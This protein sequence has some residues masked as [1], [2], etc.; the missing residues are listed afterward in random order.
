[1]LLEIKIESKFSCQSKDI[2]NQK[3][4]HFLFFR[5]VILWFLLNLRRKLREIKDK[6][7]K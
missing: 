5:I 7:V 3:I 2:T 6:E 4:F 1:M